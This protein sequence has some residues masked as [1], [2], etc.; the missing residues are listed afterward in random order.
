MLEAIRERSQSWIAKLILILI[1]V[2]FAIF[3]VDSYLRDAGSKAAVAEV[4]NEAITVQEFTQSMQETRARLEGKADANFME[5]PTVRSV[6]LDKLI[7]LRLLQNEVKHGGYTVT[8]EQLSKLIVTMPEFQKKGQF[9]QEVYDKLLA[10]NGLTPGGFEAR[11]R[12]D[13]LLGQVR[14]GIAGMAFSPDSVTNTALRARYQTREV[15]VATI[16]SEELF[17]AEKA[18]PVAVKAYYEKNKSEFAVPEQVQ[19]EYVALST[20]NLMSNVKVTDDEIKKFYQENLSKFQ[21]DEERHA[22]H[23]L[24]TFGGKTDAAS[25]AAAKKKAL[26]VLSE[27]KKSPEKFDV[28]AKKYSQDPGS[29]E[30]GG[31]LGAVKRGVMVKPFEDAVF[32]MAPG[33]IS[34]LVETDFGYHIIKLTEVKGAAP[35]LEEVKNQIHGELLSQKASA[36]FAEAAEAFSN[37]VYEQST[38]LAPAAQAHHLEVQKTG[39]M[40]RDDA[41]KFFKNNDKIANAIFSDE[42]RKEKRNTEAV[43]I[44]PNTLVAARVI[45]SRASSTK[46]FEDVKADIEKRLRQV[47]AA[48]K[49]AQ[50]GELALQ[51]LKQGK[52][53][54]GLQWSSPVIVSRTDA[55]GLTESVVLKAFQ[56]N[57]DK[58][59]AFSGAI[60]Q[61]GSYV[62]VRVNAVEDGLPKLAGDAKS[63]A[64]AEYNTLLSAE[65]LAAYLKS[66]RTEAKVKIH[67]DLLLSKTQAN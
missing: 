11:M 18:D 33:S 25:K 45:D 26:E 66:L 63:R 59:P 35:T 5:D 23:I 13:L 16:L 47:Q 61:N 24:I 62:L 57:A 38:S 55:Q 17:D 48:K 43:E 50:Q 31:D 60:S 3:G 9:S 7:N 2:P 42:V 52:D 30:R 6:V 4:N 39:W 1:T 34:D 28:L 64:I 54:S 67:Q 65:Y 22:S 10:A 53:V 12:N 32:S 27:V 15:S 20:A 51:S 40:S 19:V 37:T 49:A 56:M 14:E 46:P 58:L 29:A 36:S 8:D 21:G 41:A 44:A